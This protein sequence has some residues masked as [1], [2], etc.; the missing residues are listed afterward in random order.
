MHFKKEP[1]ATWKNTQNNTNYLFYRTQDNSISVSVQREGY[2][3]ELMHSVDGALSE[4]IYLYEAVVKF[5]CEN[6]LPLHF[7]SIGL[8][9]GYI[10]ILTCVYLFKHGNTGDFK[11]FS[12][13]SENDLVSFFKKYIYG[14]DIPADF[15]NTYEFILHAYCAY[16]GTQASEIK[17][18]IKHAVENK[19]LIFY[20]SY[21]LSTVLTDKISGV[22]F[23]AFSAGTAPELWTN[24]LIGKILNSCDLKVSFATYASRAALKRLL[25]EHGFVL[26][27]KAGYG[28]KRQSTFASKGV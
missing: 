12:F 14:E 8:G 9:V 5:A 26:E 6:N 10:E 16:Y 28:G 13:E 11:I 23:D 25:I 27:K 4:T 21:D 2:S 20:G 3:T 24:E 17:E 1:Y 19:N 7:L 18:F 22:F 15:L